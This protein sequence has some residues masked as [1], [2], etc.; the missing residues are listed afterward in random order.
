MARNNKNNNSK[1]G[2][3]KNYQDDFAKSEYQKGE[4]NARNKGGRRNSGNNRRKPFNPKSEFP[5]NIKGQEVIMPVMEGPKRNDPSWHTPSQDLADIAKVSSYYA[6]GSTIVLPRF[7]NQSSSNISV[8]IVGQFEIPGIMAMNV[9][10][11][12]GD[13]RTPNDPLNVAGNL[14]MSYLQRANGRNPMYDAANL[15]M[16]LMAVSSCYDFYS[17]MCRVYGTLALAETQNRYLPRAITY[18]QRGDYDKLKDQRA[19]FRDMINLFSTTLATL[20]LPDIYTYSKMTQQMYSRIYKDS[21][22]MKA[23][24]YMFNPSGFWIYKEGVEEHPVPY[25][26]FFSLDSYLGKTL[27]E[28]MSAKVPAGLDL[29]LFSALGEILLQPLLRSGDIR[30]MASDILEVFGDNLWKVNPIAET[31]VV[32][33]EFSQEI[34]M[35]IENAYIYGLDMQASQFKIEENTSLHGGWIQS[36]YAIIPESIKNGRVTG[37]DTYSTWMA[38]VNNAV[39]PLN[40]HYNTAMQPADVLVATRLMG[41]GCDGFNPPVG[42]GQGAFTKFRAGA[43]LVISNAYLIT[44]PSTPGSGFTTS[45][46]I[47]EFDTLNAYAYGGIET[48]LAILNLATLLS[49]WDWHPAIRFTPYYVTNG[50]LNIASSD[51]IMDIDNFALMTESQLKNINKVALI[52]NMYPRGLGGYS[53]V[54]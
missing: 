45:F 11:T 4:R 8:G 3:N 15:Q 22:S 1:N 12:F 21:N 30:M 50:T 53:P 2:S 24:L 47:R 17:W 36:D 37:Y 18:A 46:Q 41:M 44:L 52:G 7:I 32:E 6:D 13:A 19:N 54:K 35:Q 34:L 31:Y 27:S 39:V 16:Y 25:L 5:N 10:P 29:D 9:L 14:V 33:P 51:Y 48:S 42:D 43:Y 28:N 40:W 26:E 49:K 38:R 23:Q 20:P